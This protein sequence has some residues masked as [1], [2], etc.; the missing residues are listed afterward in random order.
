MIATPALRSHRRLACVLAFTLV[1]VLASVTI[2][3]IL[4]FMAIPS[5][6]AVR[7]DTEENMAIAR[8]EALNLAIS[9]FIQAYGLQTAK[10]SWD[11][12]TGAT[13]AEKNDNR[14]Q[15]LLTPYM[16]YA[17]ATLTVLMP[18]GYVATLP[19]NLQS[20]KVSIK[21]PLQTGQT[22]RADLPY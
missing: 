19:T 2:I 4:I 16:A 8:A 14:Y 9:S 3:G 22:T 20:G 6:T 10:T 1:E 12:I 7:R 15:N 17:P 11:G 18:A 5:I 21:K 13:A